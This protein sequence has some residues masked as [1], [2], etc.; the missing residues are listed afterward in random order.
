MVRTDYGD[1]VHVDEWATVD[2]RPGR[3]TAVLVHGWGSTARAYDRVT[4]LLLG[5]G[6]RM[7]TMDLPG[8]GDSTLDPAGR[9]TL[10]RLA[11]AVGQVLDR[12]SDGPTVLVAHSGA[13]LAG[14]MA[15]AGNDR[16]HGLV[17]LSTALRDAGASPPELL[18]QGSPLL[19]AAL[20]RTAVSEALLSRTMGPTSPPPTRALTAARLRSVPPATRRAFFAASRNADVTGFGRRVT[21]PT[22]LLAGHEDMVVPAT[23]VRTSALALAR[24]EFRLLP[25]KGHALPEEAPDEVVAVVDGLLSG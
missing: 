7:V 10:E 4:E 5:Q 2:G 9:V 15:V 11:V 25:G 19:N 12:F 22:V 16:L 3:G 14:V 21:V 13:G 20:R 1:A 23:S 24:G 17:L 6:R 8:H 18:I